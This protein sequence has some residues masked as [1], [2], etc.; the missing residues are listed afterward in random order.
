MFSFIDPAT[1]AGPADEVKLP[2]E[3]DALDVRLEIAAVVGGG[4]RDL[5]PE[6][7][8]PR[9]AGFTVM[10]HWATRDAEGQGTGFATSLGPTLVTPDELA[11]MRKD[12]GYDLVMTA[13]V[14]GAVRSGANLAATRWSFA[15]LLAHAS[16]GAELVPGDVIGSGTSGAGCVLELSLTPG[17]DESSWLRPGDVVEFAVAGL[18]TLTNRVVV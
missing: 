7:A 9:I 10:G 17:G 18:G 2:A 5:T 11:P 3:G 13:S 1:V 12:K 4:G 15:E 14:N 8:E 6:Q 16:R